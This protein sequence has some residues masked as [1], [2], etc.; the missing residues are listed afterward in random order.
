MEARTKRFNTIDAAVITKIGLVKNPK[1]GPANYD[2]LSYREKE[3]F[4]YGK[5]PF[6]S[7]SNLQLY[8][9]T[10]KAA[11]IPAI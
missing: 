7:Q 6:G 2:T 1:V 4:N 8:E 9:G 10:R 11:Y 3:S 5:V